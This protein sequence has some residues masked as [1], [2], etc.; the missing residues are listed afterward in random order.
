MNDRVSREQS[1]AAAAV[2]HYFILLSSS[3]GPQYDLLV[4]GNNIL[5]VFIEKKNNTVD[6][7]AFITFGTNKTIHRTP[8]VYENKPLLYV[9]TLS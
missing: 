7:C 3:S 5:H 6:R 1:T 8:R 9:S 2:R 4:F